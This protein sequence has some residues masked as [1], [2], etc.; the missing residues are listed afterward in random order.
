MIS[1]KIAREL[2]K[3][4]MFLNRRGD[5]DIYQIG[6]SIIETLRA[7]NDRVRGLD[8]NADL[9]NPFAQEEAHASW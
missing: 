5:G 2:D 8:E 1:D 4:E 9:V 7:E 3:L 6:A